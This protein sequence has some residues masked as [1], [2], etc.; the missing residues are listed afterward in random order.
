MEAYEKSEGFSESDFLAHN[1]AALKSCQSPYS[2]YYIETLMEENGGEEVPEENRVFVEEARNNSKIFWKSFLG[3]KLYFYSRYEPETEAEFFIKS[4]YRPDCERILLIGMGFGYPVKALLKLMSQEQCLWIVE[5][6]PGIFLEAL[7]NA[8]LSSIFCDE[9]VFFHLYKDENSCRQFLEEVLEDTGM[10]ASEKNILTLVTPPYRHVYK[11]LIEE[12]KKSTAYTIK[13]LQSLRNTIISF[14]ELWLSNY[15]KNVCFFDSSFDLADFFGAFSGVPA[16]LISAGP[17]LRKNIAELKSG[18]RN[19]IIFTGYTALKVLLLNGVRPD[20]VVAID[21]KQLNYETEEML[22]EKFDLPLIYSPFADSRLLQKHQGIKIRCTVSYDQYSKYLDEKSGKQV[23]P[24]YAAGTV[25]AT[26]MDIAY[27]MGCRPIV[28]AGQDLAFTDDLT[29]VPGTNY[30][31]FLKKHHY[32]M[33]QHSFLLVKDIF[34][35]EVKTDYVFLQYK[36]GLED[37]IQSKKE[38]CLFIDATEGGAKIEGTEI[39]RLADVIEKEESGI[40]EKADK[41]EERLQEIFGKSEETRKAF[42]LLAESE[43]RDSISKFQKLSEGLFI[44]SDKIQ[45]FLQKKW[46]KME[47]KRGFSLLQEEISLWNDKIDRFYEKEGLFQ[48]AVLGKIFSA[49]REYQTFSK[50]NSPEEQ[51]YFLLHTRKLYLEIIGVYKKA[52][53]AFLVEKKTE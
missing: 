42:R 46:Q 8:E 23:S 39:C 18:K 52:E 7:K 14:S 41:K 13:H 38:S 45:N 5:P 44:L 47:T 35:Q 26:M 40:L 4:L 10:P 22:R 49:E 15:L 6:D 36:K 33:K 25:A 1:I 12:I 34:G 43:I 50:K 17:S 28:F 24:L 11:T 2:K 20:F 30:D 37:Y 9:R 29:H 48:L 16:Y 32:D 53:A 3:T 27:K 21:G 19:G 31:G 51:K